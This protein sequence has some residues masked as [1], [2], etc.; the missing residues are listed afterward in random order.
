LT[1]LSAWCWQGYEDGAVRIWDTAE[2]KVTRLLKP[3]TSPMRILAYHPSEP[4]LLT[5]SYDGSAVL[6]GP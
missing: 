6:W 1:F 5:A 4:L 2:A 3:R